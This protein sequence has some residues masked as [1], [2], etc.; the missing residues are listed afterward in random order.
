MKP[1]ETKQNL[2]A[3]VQPFSKQ[4]IDILKAKIAT[5]KRT[6]GFEYEFLPQTPIGLYQ[7]EELYVFLIQ[8]GFIQDND[9]FKSPSEDI[10]IAFEP[11]GQ[12]EY[13]S[14]PLYANDGARLK[15]IVMTI[16][17]L[18]HEIESTLGIKYVGT[19]FMPGRA[20]APLCLISKRYQNLHN[21]MAFS[22]TRGR[23]MMKGTA[24]VHLHVGIRSISEII[25]F[26]TLL[27]S[28]AENAPFRMSADRRD[29]WNRTD[30]CRCG[31]PD[32]DLS[33]AIT[34]Q[35]LIEELVTFIVLADVI[36]ES[37]PFYQT[38]TISFETFLYHMT[39][40]FTD[41]RLNIKGPTIELRTMD[42]MPLSQFEEKWHLFVEKMEH[43]FMPIDETVRNLE[44]VF[45]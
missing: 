24:S 40:I 22:G 27:C 14:P 3:I 18:N 20:D 2:T 13:H 26:Y 35:Q 23:E 34:S 42:S 36:D 6:Y 45:V 28:L 29:I 7:M 10:S 11:G 1:L 9:L 17:H 39:T 44:K 43:M 37:I 5:G 12:I 31:L 41:I 4:L 16:D 25:D 38:E 8:S 19:G 32:I 15:Q 30:P 33:Q 21:R